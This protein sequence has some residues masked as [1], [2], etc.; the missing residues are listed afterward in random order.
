MSEKERWLL[1]E[2]LV[3]ENVLAGMTHLE[4]CRVARVVVE[5]SE[6]KV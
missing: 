4:A 1:F 3:R 2:G 6:G 5:G